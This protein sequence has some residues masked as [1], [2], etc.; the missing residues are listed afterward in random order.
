MSINTSPSSHSKL[1]NLSSISM[2]ISEMSMSGLLKPLKKEFML[3]MRMEEFLSMKS[4]I[5]NLCAHWIFINPLYRQLMLMKMIPKWSLLVLMVTFLSGTC[6]LKSHKKCTFF[7][8]KRKSA[9]ANGITQ[10][11]YRNIIINNK[12]VNV[13]MSLGK[14][15]FFKLWNADSLL[16]MNAV[17]TQTT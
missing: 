16:C 1:V 9:H 6:S 4:K 17:S 2:K 8:I 13:I 12:P 5:G 3:A 11:I 7:I 14:D 15:G 10:I